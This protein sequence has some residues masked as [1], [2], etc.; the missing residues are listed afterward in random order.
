MTERFQCLWQMAAGRG[1]AVKRTSYDMDPPQPIQT[2]VGLQPAK[3]MRRGP[4]G[5]LMGGAEGMGPVDLDDESAEEVSLLFTAWS[6]RDVG[7]LV[8]D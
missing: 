2:V 8:C 7:G 5:A 4:A 6:D 1:T 3:L